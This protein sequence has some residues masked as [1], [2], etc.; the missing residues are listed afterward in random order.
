M[1]DE[2]RVEVWPEL[3]LEDWSDTCDT[4]HLW[5]Q[6]VGKVA[7]KLRPF[8][9]EWWQIAFQFTPRGLTT[10]NIPYDGHVFSID[11]DFVDHALIVATSDGRRIEH[12]LTPRSVASFYREV[13]L[14]LE[15]LDIAVRIN[16]QPVEIPDAISCEVDEQHAAYD[17]RYVERWWK[18]MVNIEQ[19]LQ[20][21]RSSFVG[22]SSPAQFFWGS[23]DLSQTRFNGR[24]ASVPAGA[25]RFMR[26]A[27]DQENIACGFWPGNINMGGVTL[28]EPAFYAYIY[29]EPDGYRQSPVRPDAAYFNEQLGEFILPYDVVRRSSDPE[30]TLLEFFQ[31]TYEAATRFALWDRASLERP[32]RKGTQNHG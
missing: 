27:E 25:P 21:Y 10:G 22:K 3:P 14:A 2:T 4:L 8:L 15:R 5:T 18:I 16:P 11:F 12:P 7:L 29:P 24:P 1:N 28:G 19:V 32:S 9:N 6:I 20:R 13:M 31:S 17:Q 26:L 23:F 30:Q